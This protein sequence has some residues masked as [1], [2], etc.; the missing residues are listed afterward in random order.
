MA[1]LSDTRDRVRERYAAAA[2][3]A[4]AESESNCC[5]P[6]SSGCAPADATAMFGGAL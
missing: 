4:G 3:A 5:G 2:K 1:E 6:A